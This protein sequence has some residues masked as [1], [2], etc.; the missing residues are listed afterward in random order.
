MSHITK[1]NTNLSQTL[2]DAVTQNKSLDVMIKLTNRG[3]NLNY[4]NCSGK[5]I[6]K[7]V[8]NTGNT[9]YI[10]WLNENKFIH[11]NKICGHCF[12]AADNVCGNCL[13]CY[14]SQ[15]CQKIDWPNHK[16]KCKEEVV[17]NEP[18]VDSEKVIIIQPKIVSKKMSFQNNKHQKPIAI[19]RYNTKCW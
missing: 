13:T 5:S 4:T 15:D 18:K 17:V 3:A 8:L 9:N 12:E 19:E 16:Q 7:L 11:L 1:M 10:N 6:I 14:C 2:L